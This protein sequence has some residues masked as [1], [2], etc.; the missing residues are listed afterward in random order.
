M[1][2]L[3]IALGVGVVLLTGCQTKPIQ[4]MSYSEI[5]ELA[6]QIKKRCEDQG[7]RPPSTEWK[8]CTQQEISRE[9][10]LRVTNRENAARFQAALAQG[11]QNVSDNYAR[12]AAITAANRPVNCTHRSTGAGTVRTTCY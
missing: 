11:M 3:F 12:S 7:A 10:S 4:Q 2:H 5:V 6:A 9:R 1:K 8:L